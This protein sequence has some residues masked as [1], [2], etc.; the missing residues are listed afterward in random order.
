MKVELSTTQKLT[1]KG[2]DRLDPVTVFLEDLELGKG[3]ITIECYGKSWSAYW[4]GMGSRNIAQFFKSCDECYL[5][6]NLSN[7]SS[8]VEDCEALADKAEKILREHDHDKYETEEWVSRLRGDGSNLNQDI[9]HKIFG[10]EWWCDIPDMPNPDYQYLCRII[11]EVQKGI[12]QA[13]LLKV[14]A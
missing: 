14:K 3:K 7:I 5:S 1:I 13:G 11:T 9:M 4:G 10:D 8:Q 2:A 12:K 6:S